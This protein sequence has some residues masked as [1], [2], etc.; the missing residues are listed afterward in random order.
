VEKGLEE[1]LHRLEGAAESTGATVAAPP[2][3]P[4]ATEDEDGP[5]KKT[6]RLSARDK[7]RIEELFVMARNDRSNAYQ[8]K[9]ELDRLKVFAENEDRF[10]DLF[11]E[12]G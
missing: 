4:I 11:K 6:S 7:Q 10:L 9:Q 3:E 8:L 1:F 12:P 5:S 2:L